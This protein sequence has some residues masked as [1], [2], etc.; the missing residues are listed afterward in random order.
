M[1]SARG[2][3]RSPARRPG[4]HPR[5]R[6]PGIRWDRVG[7][8]ALLLVLGLLVLLYIRPASSYVSTWRESKQR[9]AE[10]QRFE[11]DNARLRARRAALRD[12]D[13]LELEARRLGMV[14]PGERAYVVRGLDR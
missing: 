10:V 1:A 3:A 4:P 14:K 7:R 11:R 6:R 13:A 12:D 2:A 8:V 9:H 5:R